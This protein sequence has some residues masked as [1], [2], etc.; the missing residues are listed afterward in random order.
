MKIKVNTIPQEGWILSEVI[1]PADWM[2]QTPEL[3]FLDAVQMTASFQ[4]DR[5]AVFVQ[6]VVQGKQELLCDRCATLY[7]ASYQESFDLGYSTK[8]MQTLD[9]STDIRQEILLS[10]PVRFLCMDNCLGL[11]AQ[12]GNNL[13]EG[14]C[15]CKGVLNAITQEKIFPFSTG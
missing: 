14:P 8:Q 11:C 15:N 2:L 9:I 3:K 1:S 6:V 12:C 4:K 5:D 10:Y 13:N 7:P